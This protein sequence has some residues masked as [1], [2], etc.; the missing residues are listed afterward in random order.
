M[1]GFPALK[2]RKGLE[3]LLSTKKKKGA[4]TVQAR[5]NRTHRAAAGGVLRF[6]IREGEKR[7]RSRKFKVTGQIRCLDCTAE[8]EEGKKGKCPRCSR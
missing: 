3:Y 1:N 6:M 5:T 2:G 7:K 8:G 4:L